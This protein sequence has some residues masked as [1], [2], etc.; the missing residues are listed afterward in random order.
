MTDI[1]FPHRGLV[2]MY[3]PRDLLHRLPGVS[4]NVTSYILV[5]AQFLCEQILFVF[6][7]ALV[8]VLALQTIWE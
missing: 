5:L 6:H 1:M 4:L 2:S 8:G 7:V 3:H